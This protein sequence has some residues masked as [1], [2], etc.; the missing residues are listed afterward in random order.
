MR[1]ALGH[2]DARGIA[3]EE[4]A[5][6]RRGRDDGPR[7]GDRAESDEE[8]Q[9]ELTDEA[10]EPAPAENRHEGLHAKAAGDLDNHGRGLTR[11]SGQPDDAY[12]PGLGLHDPG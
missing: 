12:E 7:R 9:G 2:R 1:G 10:E 5:G 4:E 6:P 11:L 8:D 3:W